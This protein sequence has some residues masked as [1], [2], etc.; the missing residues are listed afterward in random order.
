MFLE[1]FREG[2]KKLRILFDAHNSQFRQNIKDIIQQTSRDVSSCSPDNYLFGN[3][4]NGT[5]F[6]ISYFNI[7]FNFFFIF[8]QNV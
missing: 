2:A 4:G 7:S 6:I 8:Y 1:K 5:I 3:T